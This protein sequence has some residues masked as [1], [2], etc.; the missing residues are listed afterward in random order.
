MD[1]QNFIDL[2]LLPLLVQRTTQLLEA[3]GDQLSQIRWTDSEANTDS[4]FSRLVKS[5]KR[6]SVNLI[7]RILISQRLKRLTFK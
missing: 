6:H 7:V 5:L 3:A 1:S 2:Q 4:G